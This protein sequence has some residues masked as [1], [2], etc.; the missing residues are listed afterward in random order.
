MT[1][2]AQVIWTPEVIKDLI[3][4]TAWA[5]VGV[6]AMFLIFILFARALLFSQ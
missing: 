3:N 1:E 5:I 4:Y 6:G 2:C